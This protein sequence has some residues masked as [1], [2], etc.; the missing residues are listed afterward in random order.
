VSGVLTSLVFPSLRP[1]AG[2]QFRGLLIAF[3]PSRWRDMFAQ[4]LT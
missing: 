2:P 1:C 3:T 4:L